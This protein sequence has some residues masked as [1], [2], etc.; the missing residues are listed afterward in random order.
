MPRTLIVL[1]VCL[2]A[3]FSGAAILGGK[4]AAGLLTGGLLAAAVATTGIILQLRIARSKPAFAM[5]ALIISFGTKLMVLV[6]AALSFVF[7]PGMR[8][9]F[10]PLPFFLAFAVVSLT[11]LAFGSFEVSRLVRGETPAPA[12]D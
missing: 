1:G 11:L 7:A 6:S 9:R 4:A 10:D 12:A 2:A 3:L 8:E 5:H